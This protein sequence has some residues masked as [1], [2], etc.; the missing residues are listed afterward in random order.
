MS[1]QDLDGYVE[2]WSFI[3]RNGESDNSVKLKTDSG[4]SG[5]VS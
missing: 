5:N 2:I 1:R 4:F 3:E